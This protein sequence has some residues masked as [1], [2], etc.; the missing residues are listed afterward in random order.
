MPTAQRHNHHLKNNKSKYTQIIRMKVANVV[1]HQKTKH[2][3]VYAW[4]IYQTDYSKPGSIGL[5]A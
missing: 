5:S 4:H 2:K 3:E 1:L